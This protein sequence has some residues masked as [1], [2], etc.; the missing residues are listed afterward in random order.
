ML[1][2]LSVLDNTRYSAWW[3]KKYPARA[4]IDLVYT[5]NIVPINDQFEFDQTGF[6]A[7]ILPVGKDDQLLDLVAWK[8]TEPGKWWTRCGVYQAYLGWDQLDGPE[9]KTPH[10]WLYAGSVGFCKLF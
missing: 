9:H 1:I 10:D 6:P 4:L 8:P 2:P 5:A 7:A 3:R